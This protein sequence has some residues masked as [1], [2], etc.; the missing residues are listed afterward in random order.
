MTFVSF[1]TKSTKMHFIHLFVYLFL[2]YSIDL[3][4]SGS[5]FQVLGVKHAIDWV[6]LYT[7]FTVLVYKVYLFPEALN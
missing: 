2:I 4:L 1:L 6:P 5:S 7:D 3:I